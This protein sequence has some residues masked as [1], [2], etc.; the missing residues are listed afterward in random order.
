MLAQRLKAPILL[1]FDVVY[2]PRC[3]ACRAEVAAAHSFCYTC[4]SKVRMISEPACD[5]CGEPFDFAV[6]KGA[7]CGKCMSEPP[8]YDQAKSVMVY[9]DASKRLIT[10][11]K[12]SDRTSLAIFLSQLM[13]TRGQELV[14]TCDMIIPVPL[15][16]RRLL[17]R[18]YNQSYLLARRLSKQAKKRHA[19]N[20]LRRIRYT[21]QQTGLSR[22]ERDRNVRGA[23]K[24]SKPDQVKDKTILLVDDVLTTGATIEACARALKKSGAAKV[25][26]LTAA[27]RT[28]RG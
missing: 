12:Y 20:L 5:C 21:A 6:E 14:S 15:H 17:S 2:P 1:L 11:F 13:A 16:W 24:V 18:R 10:T 8:P 19:A 7:L 9:D 28:V 25:Y 22:T 4:F 23:F 3:V 26:V 27:R